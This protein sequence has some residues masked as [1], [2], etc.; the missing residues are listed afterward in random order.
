MG[1]GVVGRSYRTALAS[2]ATDLVTAS[3][4]ADWIP[5]NQVR[6]SRFRG[7]VQQDPVQWQEAQIVQSC[8]TLADFLPGFR[9]LST[10]WRWLVER[11]RP[12]GPDRDQ[13]PSR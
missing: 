7:S 9:P 10:R 4:P 6:F 2:V 5:A 13:G 11:I 3:K 12:R 8:K 1:Y